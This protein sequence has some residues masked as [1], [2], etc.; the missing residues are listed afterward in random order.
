MPTPQMVGRFNADQHIQP[1]THKILVAGTLDPFG[2]LRGDKV[3]IDV[4]KLAQNGHVVACH[5]TFEIE[6]PTQ[7]FAWEME[8]SA[9]AFG[10]GPAEGAATATV[11]RTGE[12][13]S[14]KAPADPN[15][16]PP[17]SPTPPLNI[18]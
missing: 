15:P 8:V 1:G 4:T 18:V 11:K 9:S 6:D 2:L 13:F 7:Q 14:W 3:T 10:P 16:N 5:Q 12:M 17:P